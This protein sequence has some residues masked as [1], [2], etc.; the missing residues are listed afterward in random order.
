MMKIKKLR[1]K[2]VHEPFEHFSLDPKE[3]KGLIE[4]AIE[5]LKAL[6]LPEVF[7]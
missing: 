7:K 5:C 4:E 6:G 3:A 2:L 1:N